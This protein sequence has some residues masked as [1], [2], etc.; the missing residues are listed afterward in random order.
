[1]YNCVVGGIG[2]LF[3]SILEVVGA[4]FDGGYHLSINDLNDF[5]KSMV[6]EL[7]HQLF[8]DLDR[9][10]PI[11]DLST[12]ATPVIATNLYGKL[13][14]NSSSDA[15][16]H[17]ERVDDQLLIDQNVDLQVKGYPND[18]SKCL[19]NERRCSTYRRKRI[20]IKRQVKVNMGI[21]VA[22]DDGYIWRKHGQ[23]EILG[24][25]Y[26]RHYYRCNFKQTAGCRALKQVQRSD[27]DPSVFHVSYIG[28]HT[29]HTVLSNNHSSTATDSASIITDNH[30]EYIKR[31]QILGSKK[32]DESSYTLVEP[33]IRSLRNSGPS[34][35][36]E[37]TSTITDNS[38]GLNYRKKDE[39]SFA[40]IE[41]ELRSLSQ[42]EYST[43]TDLFPWT[44]SYEEAFT[45]QNTHE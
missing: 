6:E 42:A 21:E 4:T 13:N 5:Q 9:M 40:F 37:S 1:M 16:E 32:K 25:K 7:K 8:K 36:A 20:I 31:P 28:E 30:F 38:L 24:S 33:E 10:I 26:P 41:P 11:N 45:T 19:H 17:M 22:P 44:E 18:V 23:K 29:C 2:L 35:A 12:V 39:V 34:T 3:N 27:E 15:K 14:Q 43:I